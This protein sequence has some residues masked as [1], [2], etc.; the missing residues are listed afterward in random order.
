MKSN[1][2][3]RTVHWMHNV[4]FK[5]SNQ[6]HVWLPQ[7]FSLTK[8]KGE[9]FKAP[10]QQKIAISA[11][12]PIELKKFD[13]SQKSIGNPPIPLWRLNISKNGF[14]WNFCC[15]WDKFLNLELR[16]LAFFKAKMPPISMGRVNWFNI[17]IFTMWLKPYN[18]NVWLNQSNYDYVKL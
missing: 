5:N 2:F 6:D 1:P 17:V 18:A 14:L 10:Y 16:F 12:I 15:R 3:H 11:H 9:G 8:A 4:R 13:S 7:I